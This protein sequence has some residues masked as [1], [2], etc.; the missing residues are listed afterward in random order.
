MKS[1]GEVF[2]PLLGSEKLSARLS[3]GIL[4]KLNICNQAR[5]ITIYVNFDGLI[6]RNELFAA[7]GKICNCLGLSSAVIKPHFPSELFSSDYFP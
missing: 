2:N 6:E 1:L 7:E 4:T 3:N 5:S